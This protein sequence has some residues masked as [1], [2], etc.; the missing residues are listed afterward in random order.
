MWKL[1][2]H[3][4][5]IRM[6]F[7]FNKK[8][9][10]CAHTSTKT[11]FTNFWGILVSLCTNFEEILTWKFNLIQTIFFLFRDSIDCLSALPR[12]WLS[13][14]FVY[15][16]SQDLGLVFAWSVYQRGLPFRVPAMICSRHYFFPS[17]WDEVLR[18]KLYL[19]GSVRN[20]ETSQNKTYY[21][22]IEQELFFAKLATIMHR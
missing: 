7:C 1:Q 2:V 4:M 21:F 16:L 17:R 19:N 11:V 10:N 8:K 22:K 9:N 20:V 15:P 3:C 14:C 6:N 13:F 12:L 18:H 5:F